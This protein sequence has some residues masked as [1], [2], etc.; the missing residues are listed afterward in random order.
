MIL[1]PLLQALGNPMFVEEIIY[2][3]RD[4]EAIRVEGGECMITGDMANLDLPSNLQG[5]IASR[6]DS[7]PAAPQMVLKVG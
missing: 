1:T 6:I 3:L 5:V 2:K 7:L 4:A